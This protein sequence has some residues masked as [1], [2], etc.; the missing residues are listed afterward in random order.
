MLRSPLVWIPC[1]G[2]L[3]LALLGWWGFSLWRQADEIRDASFAAVESSAEAGFQERA[4]IQ[5]RRAASHRMVLSEGSVFLALGLVALVALVRTL[6]TRERL[7]LQETLFLQTIT[8][9]LRTPLQ[10]LRLA[11]E[12]VRRRPETTS[13]LDHSAGMLEDLARLEGMVENALHA[14]RL[15]SGAVHPEPAPTNLS[16]ALENALANW[17]ASHSGVGAVQ[18]R[19]APDCWAEADPAALEVI[20]ANLLDNAC[21]YGAPPLQV[22]LLWDQGRIVLS[23]QDQ[24]IGFPPELN[25]TLWQRFRRSEQNEVKAQPGSGLGLH[26][27]ASLAHAQGAEVVAHSAGLGQGAEFR[28]SWPATGPQQ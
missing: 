12:T 17:R 10:S 13:L 25:R 18:D 27:V 11:V 22:Q 4:V 14:G 24:G 20:L 5:E 6:R 2:S 1:L 15:E 26:I 28:V 21:K 19:I 16:L 8:H 9:E 3:Y 7:A 23:V